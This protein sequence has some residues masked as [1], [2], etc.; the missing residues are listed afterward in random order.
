MIGK[1]GLDNL[2]LDMAAVAP[3]SSA[4]ALVMIVRY[5]V[6]RNNESVIIPTFYSNFS[7]TFKAGK[8]T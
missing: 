3:F 2:S 6:E 7:L 8:G 1:W 5:I 4:L